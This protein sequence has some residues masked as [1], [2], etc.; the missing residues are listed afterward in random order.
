MRE[1]Y[2]A[3]LEDDLLWLEG[4]RED[5]EA[6][7]L[8]VAAQQEAAN[9]AERSHPGE[10]PHERQRFRAAI[11]EVFSKTQV[12]DQAQR[13]LEEIKRLL[14]LGYIS[15]GYIRP[16]GAKILLST[17]PSEPGLLDKKWADYVYARNYHN[18]CEEVPKEPRSLHLDR[19]G[20]S[21]ELL[22]AR[23]TLIEGPPGSGTT[24]LALETA[25]SWTRIT[26]G[27][28]CYFCPTQQEATRL[29]DLAKTLEPVRASRIYFVPGVDP[30]WAEM[31]YPEDYYRAMASVFMS[32]QGLFVFD[33]V[34]GVPLPPPKCSFQVVVA[35]DN[36]SQDCRKQA[37]ALWVFEQPGKP[38]QL[39]RFPSE[40]AYGNGGAP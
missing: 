8:R 10:L 33:H 34:E 12:Q 37:D 32:R 40:A 14:D 26:G 6:E 39:R 36:P 18:A 35:L 38:A 7:R 21:P 11:Q 22:K 25:L 19:R 17:P 29:R 3:Y 23:L 5:L 1:R 16:E 13:E 30:K 15:L 27:E 9:R 2:N 20:I 24:N 28:V 31:R 4:R